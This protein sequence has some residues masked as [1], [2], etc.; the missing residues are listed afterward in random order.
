MDLEEIIKSSDLFES[1]KLKIKINSSNKFRTYD[2]IATIF[3]LY[4]GDDDD[5]F[6]FSGDYASTTIWIM[7]FYENYNEIC[8][9]SEFN[10]SLYFKFPN[11]CSKSI[12]KDI[13]SNSYHLN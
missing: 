8:K 9:I 10:N 4:I 11:E 3:K 2:Q 1:R 5:M 7:Y 6:S 13:I 12:F